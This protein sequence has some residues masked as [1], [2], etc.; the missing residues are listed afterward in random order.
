MV[1]G[2]NSS[3]GEHATHGRERVMDVSAT[4]LQTWTSMVSKRVCSY[5]EVL[6]AFG[7]NNSK[8]GIL[9]FN[10]FSPC[11]VQHVIGQ[12]DDYLFI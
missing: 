7:F 4:S 9:A 10:Q 12:F 6:Q 5:R 3:S 11:T 2:V 8:N 1:G